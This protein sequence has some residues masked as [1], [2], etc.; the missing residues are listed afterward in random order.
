MKDNENTIKPHF[1]WKGG[2]VKHDCIV[3]GKTFSDW[4]SQTTGK[5]CNKKCYWKDKKGRPINLSEAGQRKQSERFTGPNNPRWRGGVTKKHDLIRRS[6]AYKTWRQK[7]Y[8]K[9]RWT[10][11]ECGKKCQTGDIIAHHIMLFSDFPEERFN[12]KNG[13]VL[14]RACH[15]KVHQ[16][17]RQFLKFAYGQNKGQ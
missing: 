15:L 10:C 8:E 6:P 16:F 7:V 12:P 9:S 3:C 13:I 14:H 2:K 4:P 1:N 11:H 17:I 5:F